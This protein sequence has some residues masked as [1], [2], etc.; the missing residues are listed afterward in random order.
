MEIK[1]NINK[2]YNPLDPRYIISTKSGRK[3]IIGTIDENKPKIF[4]RRPY[5]IDSKRILRTD[6]IEGAQP[7]YKRS[8]KPQKVNFNFKHN[9]A[10]V[11]ELNA[12]GGLTSRRINSIDNNSNEVSPNQTEHLIEING[13]IV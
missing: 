2:D 7:Y 13:D 11:E 1:R 4:L 6:D 10:L 5:N 9:E 8:G 3:Q 12:K